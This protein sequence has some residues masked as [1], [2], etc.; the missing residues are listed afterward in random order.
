MHAVFLPLYSL[1]GIIQHEEMVQKELTRFRRAM[2]LL[3]VLTVSMTLAAQELNSHLYAL[4]LCGGRNRITNH[5]RYWNDCSFIYRTLSQ[6]YHLPKRNIVVLMADGNNPDNDMLR[7]DGMG[8]ISSPIDLDGDGQPDITGAATSQMVSTTLYRLT[9]QLTSD[10]HLFLFVTDHGGS[11]GTTG[12][13]NIWLWGDEVVKDYQLALMLQQ[14]PTATITV[15]MGQCHSGG[16]IDDLQHDGRIVMT[17]CADSEE[18]WSC[19][20]RD[21][22]EF[23]YH[24]ICAVNGADEAGNVVDADKNRDG[25]VSMHEAFDYAASH[26]RRPETP[27]YASW[28]QQLGEEWSL[29]SPVMVAIHEVEADDGPAA[30]WSLSGVPQPSGRHGLHIVRKNGK[31]MIKL[32]N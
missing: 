21:Y 26:D 10:D 14:M 7:T 25:K 15:V 6:R 23:L 19:P 20:D 32:K 27:Q 2:V 18:S 16:F 12:D 22:D 13:S 8:F 24:W 28:P 29:D 3:A 1:N 5:E 31:T 30:E 9:Q 11:Y 17:A 4:L